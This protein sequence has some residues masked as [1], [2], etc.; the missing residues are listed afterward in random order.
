MMFAVAPKSTKTDTQ[1]VYFDDGLWQLCSLHVYYKHIFIITTR[2]RCLVAV[3]G[4]SAGYMVYSLM[5]VLLLATSCVL[6]C[7]FILLCGAALTCKMILFTTCSICFTFYLSSCGYLPP[8]F[9]HW[10]FGLLLYLFPACSGFSDAL[11]SPQQ[12]RPAPYL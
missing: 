8:Q 10:L 5:C 2:R 3:V 7:V 12:L 9:L 6:F 4:C 11:R 1:V